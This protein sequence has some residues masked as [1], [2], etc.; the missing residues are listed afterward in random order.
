MTS[1]DKQ[2]P[3]SP[4]PEG[5]ESGQAPSVFAARLQRLRETVH[6]HRRPG[7]VWSVADMVAEMTERGHSV[8]D[9]TIRNQLNKTNPNPTMR[10]L[11]GLADMFDVPADYFSASER[12][13]QLADQVE[14][15]VEWKR[16]ESKHP[17]ATKFLARMTDLSPG[18][19]RNALEHVKHLYALEHGEDDDRSG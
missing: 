15:A 8:S 10:V 12:G 3:G 7:E 14:V 16:L 2:Q 17:G 9:Q 11:E 1:D 4:G 6:N 5:T 18:S 13:Q 19:A